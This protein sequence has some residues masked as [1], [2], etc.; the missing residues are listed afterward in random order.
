MRRTKIVAT[1]GPASRDHAVLQRL[2]EA[3][4]DVVRLNFSHGQHAEHLAVMAIVRGTAARSGRAVALLQGLSGP[5]IRTG[6]VRDG[7]PIELRDGQSL[8]I[9]TDESVDGTEDLI[10]TTYDPLPRDVSPGDTILLDDGNLELRV[11]ETAGGTVR[12]TVVHGGLLS[13]NKGMNLPGV[14][15]SAPALT[16]KDR[17]DLAFGVRNGV[18][19]V[20]LSFVRS[21]QDVQECRALIRSLGGAMPVI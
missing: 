10:A 19:F 15:L 6:R 18:D 11:L 7:K 20:A 14:K 8:T 3:G 16:E 9:T 1:I 4:V 13:S 21:A 2:I 5:K 12:C 17:Y